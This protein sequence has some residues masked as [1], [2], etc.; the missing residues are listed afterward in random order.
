VYDGWVHHPPQKRREADTPD[1]GHRLRTAEKPAPKWRNQNQQQTN[2]RASEKLQRPRR[3]EIGPYIAA[4]LNQRGHD[5]GIGEC[6]YQTLH[7]QSDPEQSKV[8]WRQ[9]PGYQRHLN[10]ARPRG[11]GIAKDQPAPASQDLFA[12]SSYV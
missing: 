3:V 12:Q 6:L 11:Q 1:C 2:E 7:Y 8:T 5:A 4:L 10:D 9:Q